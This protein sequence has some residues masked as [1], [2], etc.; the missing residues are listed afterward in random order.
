MSEE[1]VLFSGTANP[2]LS[3]QI[4]RELGAPLA[5]AQV[6]RFPDGEVSVRLGASVRRKDVF[7]IQSTSPPVDQ[8]LVELLAFVDACRRGAAGQ[9]IAVVP[10]FGYARSDKRVWR[11]E[12]IM[13][14]VV[15]DLLQA[16]GV[17]H[18]FT[19]DLHTPQIEGFFRVPVDGLTAVP[20]LCGVLADSLPTG[21]VVVAPDV[22]RVG[23]ATAFANRLGVSV[24]V[25]HKRR[26]SGSETQITHVVGTVRDRPCLIVDDIIASAGT[27]SASIA[28][29][30]EAG[31]RPEI[32]VAAT[33]G[34]LVGEARQRLAHPAIRE[35]LLTDTVPIDADDR[36]PLRVVTV[37]RLLA[38]AIRRYMA[39]DSLAELF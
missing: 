29:L 6:E 10:Y 18:L 2:A 3:G 1:F 11:R 35:V 23:L 37:S 5:A 21:T 20:T 24:A 7:L 30:L 39:N 9:V 28:A 36:L 17:D 33:H 31:A 8:H 19:I 25:L 26:E 22:G 12:P 32:T 14:R 27:I 38:A 16:I 15:A 34:L 4:A 13:A